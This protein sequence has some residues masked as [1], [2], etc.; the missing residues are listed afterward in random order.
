MTKQHVKSKVYDQI[1][2]IIQV[3]VYGQVNDDLLTCNIKK[4]VYE[5]VSA[6]ITNQIDEH[7][8]EQILFQCEDN[9]KK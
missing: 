6:S 5:Q 1:R 8:L 7:I 2:A 9:F 4:V 3:Q